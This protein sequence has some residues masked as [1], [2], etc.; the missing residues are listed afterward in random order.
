MSELEVLP[1]LP[2][3]PHFPIGPPVLE[4]TRMPGRDHI[5]LPSILLAHRS[6]CILRGQCR[7]SAAPTNSKAMRRWAMSELQSGGPG[8]WRV[9]G[10]ETPESGLA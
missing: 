7:V 4:T 10:Q 1:A 6:V 3:H 9:G 2:T 8:L 5:F